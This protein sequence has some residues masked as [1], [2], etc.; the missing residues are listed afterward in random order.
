M[1][2]DYFIV[3]LTLEMLVKPL[4]DDDIEHIFKRVYHGR[5]QILRFSFWID[6]LTGVW[7]GDQKVSH[8]ELGI[9]WMR[10]IFSSRSWKI[11]LQGYSIEHNTWDWASKGNL[12]Y[13]IVCAPHPSIIISF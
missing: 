2:L 8:L 3:M 9:N 7:V 1:S 12:P 11:Y 6:G 13:L 10:S 5:S 4:C